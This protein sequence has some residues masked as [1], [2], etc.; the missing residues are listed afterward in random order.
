VG[1]LTERTVPFAGTVLR[2]AVAP[3]DRVPKGAVL[4]VLESMKMEHVVEAGAPGTISAVAVSEGDAVQAGDVL[5]RIDESR[6][7]P[8]ADVVED[9]VA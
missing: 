5:L 7:A 9:E 6:T 4:L 3:G 2:V 1:G 8:L